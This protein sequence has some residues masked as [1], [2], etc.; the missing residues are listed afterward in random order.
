[1]NYPV[2][3]VWSPEDERF[4][5]H[6]VDL[7]GCV[8]DGATQAEALA[9][10]DIIASD[11]IATAQALDREI[12]SP[13]SQEDLEA[14]TAEQQRAAAQAFE[15]AVK[16]AVSDILEDLVPKIARN[17]EGKYFRKQPPALHSRG[18]FHHRILAG[19]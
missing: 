18:V 13:S 15:E 7:P 8:A 5:A 3:I 14:A 9:N 12:P 19:A 10:A 2:F 4:L 11:W 6:V 1:M 17:L 16:T